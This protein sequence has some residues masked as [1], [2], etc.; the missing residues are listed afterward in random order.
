MLSWVS[1]CI[2]TLS[3]GDTTEERPLPTGKHKTE[4]FTAQRR[5]TGNAREMAQ[6][7]LQ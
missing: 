1:V 6:R 3:S 2:G 7:D 5:T 4:F